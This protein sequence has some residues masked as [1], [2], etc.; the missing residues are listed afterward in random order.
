[1]TEESTDSIEFIYCACGCGFTRPKYDSRGRLGKFILRHGRTKPKL[2]YCEFIYCEC[3]CGLTCPKYLRN[4]KNQ[5]SRFIHG[6]NKLK[7]DKDREELIICQC[8]CGLTR[9]KYDQHLVERKY[10]PGHNGRGLKP[11]NYRGW[12]MHKSGYIQIY[13]PEHPFKDNRGYV[14]E[15]RLVMEQHLG[16]Y[17]TKDEIVHHKNIHNLSPIENRSDNT[18]ENLEL[19]DS[20]SNH[21]KLHHGRDPEIW[22]RI[23]YYCTTNKVIIDKIGRPRWF[24]TNIPTQ[25]KCG[26][27]YDKIR[28]NKM[29]ILYY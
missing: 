6:H 7:S 24:K 18:L 9:T 10:I 19:V 26:G 29:C 17:L 11:W 16:R 22:N 4:R 28:R 23:C 14:M 12:Q 27:C 25:Y 21:I 8:G 15:H 20:Q 5:I 13:F 3:G 2:N 1:M